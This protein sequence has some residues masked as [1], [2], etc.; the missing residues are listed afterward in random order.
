MFAYCGN[1][2]VNYSDPTGRMF[3]DWDLWSNQEAGKFFT[4]WYIGT[5]ENERD[6]NGKFTLDAKIK[7]TFNA[8]AYNIEFSCGF[9]QGLF[10]ERTFL[11]AGCAF[12]YL[13]NWFVLDY[14]DGEWRTGQ[15]REYSAVF[16]ISQIVEMGFNV[17]LFRSNGRTDASDSWVIVNNKKDSWTLFSYGKYCVL[18]GRIRIGFDL[19][20]FIEQMEYIWE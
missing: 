18:G 14:S 4:E 20:T 16:Y 11:G 10:K 8:I 12:G 7:R 1:N 13:E 6:S 15:E 19:N 9:G 5:D 3:R 2:P 17:T